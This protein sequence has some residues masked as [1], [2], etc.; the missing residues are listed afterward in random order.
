MKRAILALLLFTLAFAIPVG[1]AYPELSGVVPIT[2]PDGQSFCTAFVINREEQLLL[3]ADHC[4]GIP[5]AP[6]IDGVPAVEIYHDQDLDVA[7]LKA[8]GLLPGRKELN[9]RV[10]LVFNEDTLAYGYVDNQLRILAGKLAVPVLWLAP[11]SPMF[12]FYTPAAINGMS[13]GPVVGADGLVVAVNQR[14]HP[15]A[16]L[17]L[18]F[19]I[20]EIAQTTEM[21]WGAE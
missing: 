10:G 1:G 17:S 12:T 3:T 5:F 15:S 13:G 18:S 9:Y 14:A 4:M 7:V 16:E 19:N 6:F 2:A 20:N 21:Y 8:P 11:E